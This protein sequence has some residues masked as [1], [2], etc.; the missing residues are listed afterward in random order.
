[1]T[2]SLQEFLASK[3]P[4]FDVRSPKEY[5]HSHIPGAIS[6]P[7]FSD[8]ERVIVGTA[9]KQQG[10]DIAVRLGV[11]L[12]G[13]KLDSILTSALEQLSS[14]KNAR[15]YCWRGGMRSGFVRYFLEF[16]GISSI[17]LKGGYKAYRRHALT[18]L[19]LPFKPFLIGG[20]TGSGK[21]EV[22]QALG[23]LHAQTIDLEALACHRGS[24]YGELE[25][26]C[27]PSCEQFE[28]ELAF[29]LLQCNRQLPIWLEDES[30]LIGRCQIPG[31]FYDAMQQ[32]PLFVVNSYK[33]ARVARIVS[34]YSTFARPRLVE[35]TQKL[36]KRLGGVST[37][38]ALVCIEQGRLEDAVCLL[39]EYYDKAYEHAIGK[40][41]GAV[42]RLAQQELSAQE[43][44]K[45]VL[46]MQ[47]NYNSM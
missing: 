2:V 34:M 23:E 42:I 4:C 19:Q 12:I 13:P 17:Q 26:S 11:K 38:E 1:M 35:M 46:E 29:S 20:L 39:L 33:E 41:K 44:A 16:A 6:L 40:H 28:N 7:L 15:V 14:H 5:K 24:V 8:D 25:G 27:Q 22:L 21:T 31:N 45:I 3:A 18:T 43:W 10:K 47:C 30:R 32:A 36:A 37:K 9:Y